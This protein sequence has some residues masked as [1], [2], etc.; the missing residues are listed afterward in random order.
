MPPS[1]TAAR[2][3]T[4]RHPMRVVTRR[5]GLSA[6]I[7]RVWERRYQ[8]VTPS[9]TQTGRR[10][11]S[12]ADIERLHLL[13]RATLGGRTIGAVAELP[14]DEIKEL[15]RQD[16]AAELARS[17][18]P[19]DRRQDL[20]Q[21]RP[22]VRDCMRAIDRFDPAALGAMLHRASIA[23]PA[24]VFLEHVVAAVLEQVGTR[25]REGSFRPVHGH[26][27]A[28]VVRRVLEN[29]TV[30][31][32]PPAPRLLM[33][34]VTGQIHELG[35]MIVA[36]AASAEGWAVTW[37]GANLPA[38]DIADAAIRLR[39]RA[40]GVSLIHP[41]G[42]PAVTEELRRLRALLPAPVALLVGGAAAKS[43]NEALTQIGVQPSEDL[44]TLRSRLQEISAKT[45]PTRRQSGR[46]RTTSANNS[47][48]AT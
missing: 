45:A 7:L 20:A 47:R 18:V 28:T 15:L 35:A 16:A 26:L 3:L 31:A 6:E 5:T 19:F 22:L 14:N 44:T 29:T 40:V 46:R 10:L 43:Y 17:M 1:S 25:W 23:L 27:A 2:F 32:P 30:A 12:D 41:M 21:A 9:R 24:T 37:L 34:T 48:S 36:A 11:Y 13:S 8:V 38:A 39:V 33:A 4:H 42:D